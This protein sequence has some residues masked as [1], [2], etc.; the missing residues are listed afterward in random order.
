MRR[1]SLVANCVLL[2][3]AGIGVM[4]YGQANAT[5]LKPLYSQNN[6]WRLLPQYS[7]EFDG[8]K[9]DSAKW[10]NDVADWGMWSWEPGNVSVNDGK[11]NL[12]MDY[13]EHRRGQWTLYYKS[14][15]VKS[16]APPVR[17]GYFE[18]RIKAAS[19]Y[20]G[21]APAFWGYRQDADKWTEIDFV[22]LTQRHR[23]VK[24]VDTNVHVFR[25]AEFPGTLPLQ[26]ER[27]WMAPWDPRDDFHVYGC[28]WDEQQIR[29]YVDGELIQ[30][31]PNEH[32]HQALDVVISFGVRGELKKQASA[33]GFPTSF[34]VDYVRVWS[35]S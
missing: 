17:Y 13:S 1:V 14:G 23:D 33:E 29:W 5:G 20:P 3:C 15:I 7:D 25:Q 31:R 12:R 6:A 34:Q 9:L 11:L 4:E 2:L 16:K 24:I 21:V 10:D 35:S 28:E 32:W 30:T 8:A 26:E 19:R 22:E 18:A 27:S